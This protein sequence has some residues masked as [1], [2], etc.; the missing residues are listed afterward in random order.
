MAREVV[1]LRG[2]NVGGSH[3]LPMSALRSGLE[4]SG[5][6][7]VATYI[8]SGN[9]VLT[10]PAPGPKDLG[11]WLA[12]IIADVAGFEVPVVLRTVAELERA[13]TRNPYPDAGGT[14]LHVVFF[15]EPPDEV[16]LGGVDRATFAPEEFTLVGRDL[17]LHLPN[18]MGRARLPVAL[19]KAGRTAARPGVGTAR[20]WKTVLKLVELA[21]G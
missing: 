11:A 19:E 20:N 14:E 15:A 2:V 6:T 3:T 10:P 8:Q 9:V 21:K 1:L 12:R 5:C 17:Y 4:A 13:V 16:A 18:G 7:D